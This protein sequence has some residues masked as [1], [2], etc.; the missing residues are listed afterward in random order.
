MDQQKSHPP[1]IFRVLLSLSILVIILL[2]SLLLGTIQK[3]VAAPPPLPTG[4]PANP[5]KK[6]NTLIFGTT[7]PSPTVTFTATATVTSTSTPNPDHVNIKIRG[8]IQAY[9]LSCEASASVDW[10]N[11]FG[12]TIYEY[13]FQTL[14]PHSDN[15]DYGFVG[16]VNSKWGQVPPYAYGVYAG[17]VA[18]LLRQ[19]GL[20]AQAVKGYTLAEV[21]QKL[22]ESKPIMVWVIGNMEWSK[23]KEYVD[24]KGNKTLVAPF[25]HVVI[26]TGYDKDK[27]RYMSEG[28]FYDAPTDVFLTSWGVLGNMAVIYD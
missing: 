5:V 1:T 22:A 14:L 24:S 10:A 11:Y 25:E 18:D 8:H 23:A 28:S 21:K 13:T 12:V 4:S 7:T 17:P 6:F 26:L 19:Y 3:P 20:P 9:H 15:P 16:D 2:V 27:I